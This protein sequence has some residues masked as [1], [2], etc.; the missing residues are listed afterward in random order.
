MEK[1]KNG[2][3]FLSAA[4]VGILFQ[5]LSISTIFLLVFLGSRCYN[6]EMDRKKEI[7]RRFLFCLW[8]N[9]MDGNA[10]ES[11]SCLMDI[12]GRCE[13]WIIINTMK[14]KEALTT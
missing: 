14:E 1:E 7:G 5:L 2:P 3:R 9:G 11:Y 10:L 4:L 12:N 6:E 13:G 8:I